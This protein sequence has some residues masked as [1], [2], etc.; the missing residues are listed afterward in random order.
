MALTFWKSSCR[1]YWLAKVTGRHGHPCGHAT[2]LLERPADTAW[3]NLFFPSI[4][5]RNSAHVT[6]AR[7]GPRQSLPEVAFPPKAAPVWQCPLVSDRGQQ[8]PTG[9]D[10]KPPS[11]A[12]LGDAVL[13]CLRLQHLCRCPKFCMRRSPGFSQENS[14]HSS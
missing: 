13:R 11:C 9:S 10:P 4:F 1:S 5:H 3:T 14:G 7:T 12:Y 8:G 6:W 2:C